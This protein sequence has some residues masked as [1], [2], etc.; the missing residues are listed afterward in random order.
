MYHGRPDR[1]EIIR[2]AAGVGFSFDHFTCQG[3]PNCVSSVEGRLLG[4]ATP[5]GSSLLV[6]TNRGAPIS[7]T[8]VP[9]PMFQQ[10]PSSLDL[11]IERVE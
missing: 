9:W 7:K 2:G 10:Q 1:G 6:A 3:L 4:G 8:L 11:R 5:V